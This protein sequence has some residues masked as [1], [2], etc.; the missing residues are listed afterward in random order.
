MYIYILASKIRRLYV[1]VTNHLVRRIW[2][3]RCGLVPGFT[4]RYGIKQLVYFATI[5][6]A[7]TAI[8]REKQIKDYAA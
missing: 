3:H 6:E 7:Q 5:Q 4:R 8:K 1:G 2:E